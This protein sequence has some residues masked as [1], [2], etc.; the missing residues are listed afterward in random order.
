MSVKLRLS[1]GG[2]KKR[3][4][5][6]IV[7]AS[8]LVPRDGKFLEKLGTYNPLLPKDDKNRVILNV[9]RISYWLSNGA[10]PTEVVA[11]FIAKSGLELPSFLTKKIELK[12]KSRKPAVKK[13]EAAAA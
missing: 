3:P 5:Y 6:K 2:R 12:F 11:K 8:A 13:S 1:R 10:Q 9:E 7:A 4:F